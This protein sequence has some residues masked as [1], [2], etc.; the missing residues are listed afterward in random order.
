MAPTAS[1]C[2]SM[3]KASDAASD[4]AYSSLLRAAR[5][6]WK[7]I[8]P[9]RSSSR[10]QRRL[11]SSVYCF[12]SSRSLRAHTFQSRFLSGSPGM[13]GRCSANSTLKPWK[14]LRCMPAMKPSTT[15]RART[16]RCE[17]RATT[18]GSRNARP[19]RAPL[20]RPRSAWAPEDERGAEWVTPS[21]L[22]RRDHQRALVLGGRTAVE[23]A[24]DLPAREP[25]QPQEQVHF[26]RA[27]PA[28]HGGEA[29]HVHR[30]PRGIELVDLD[31]GMLGLGRKVQAP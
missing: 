13:Y 30:R 9:D 20:A 7:P 17:S 4:C 26:A 11:V 25:R 14:G 24:G 16:S 21:R 6:E 22:P 5:G 12:T 10:W 2:C 1:C 15:N 3:R 29:V 23:P 27:D 18:A 31:P 19:S 8:E 28:H